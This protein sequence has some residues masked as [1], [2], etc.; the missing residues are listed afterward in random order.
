MKLVY[1]I[2]INDSTTPT[3]KTTHNL[4]RKRIVLWRCP[5]YR[6]WG[7][8]LERVYSKK[9]LEKY[10]TYKDCTVC[11]DWLTFSNFKAW[12]EQQ[13]WEDKQLDKDLLFPGNKLYSPETC[14][15]ISGVI[16]KFLTESCAT[17]G[18]YPIGVSFK[19]RNSKYSASVNNPFTGKREHLG[20]FT[21]PIKAH[22]AWRKRKLEL[23]CQLADLQTDV[24]VIKA[25]I[26]R[27][28]NYQEVL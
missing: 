12:M 28:E 9:H 22:S 14:V 11:D 10:P 1:G 20:L 15:F 6:V 25:L 26:V 3:Q 5:F 16:N 23:A 8:M 2:G 17:R 24:R 7:S 4:E 19:Q 18:L 13:D 27:Y 21:C